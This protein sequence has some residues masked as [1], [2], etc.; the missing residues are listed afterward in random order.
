MPT[1]F[2][3]SVFSATLYVV[4]AHDVLD[5]WRWMLW[6]G[7]MLAQAAARGLLWRAFRRA[8]PGPAQM[9]PWGRRAIAGSAA[10]GCIWGLGAVLVFPHGHIEYEL[11]FM[12][13]IASMGSISAIASASFLPAFYAYTFP[14]VLPIALQLIARDETLLQ[15]MGVIALGYLPVISRFAHNLGDAV[16]ESFRLRFENLDLLREVTARKEQAED[17]NRE[18]SMFLAAASHDLR[19][20]LHALALQAHVLGQ[21]A[22]TPPQRA[23][24]GS[25]EAS[26]EAMTGLFDALLDV[27][28]LDAGVVPVRNQPVSMQSVFD[29]LAAE[30]GSAARAKNLALRLRP[31]RSV[32]YT[33]AHLLATLL[34]NLVSNAIRYTDHGGVL[35]CAR[36]RGRVWRVQVWDTGIGIAP[37]HQRAVFKAFFQVGNAERDRSRGLGLGLAITERIADLLRLPLQ[38]RSQPGHGTVFSVDLQVGTATRPVATPG[39][40]GDPGRLEGACVLVLDNEAESRAAMAALLESWGCRVITAATAEEAVRRSTALTAPPQLLVCDFRLGGGATGPD[41]IERLREE[42][43]LT[44]PALVITGDTGG[45]VLRLVQDSGCLMLHKPVQPARLRE[46]LLQ[47]LARSSAAP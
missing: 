31:T 13:L 3:G 12:F 19:Q 28:R 45:E 47:L 23:S 43:N 18:K 15:V 27:S 2:L 24:L 40:A 35:V 10:S 1:S 29:Q 26:V 36:R 7:L 5:G 11:L 25:I 8:Q 39:P 41:V 46:S 20:P 33:D 42:F 44:I 22:L 17:A 30:F 34:R 16:V 6:W 4:A 32:V 9:R 38:L 14:T 21:T 37:E